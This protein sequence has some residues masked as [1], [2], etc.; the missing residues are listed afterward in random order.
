M[1][2]NWARTVLDINVG[3]REDLAR[4]RRVLDEVA[5]D[6]WEDDDFRGVIIEQPEVW[7]VES[8]GVDGIVVRVT[9]KT[10]PME[11]W[12]VARAMRERIKARFDHEG[13]EIPY[14]QRV[15]WHREAGPVDDPSAEPAAGPTA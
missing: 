11:Q 9:L 6:L 7:G 8:L 2:Q 12:G 3:Y 10:A 4:V 14:P 13:I 5:H 1:S 15:V